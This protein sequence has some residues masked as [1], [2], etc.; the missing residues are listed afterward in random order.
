MIG[1]Q[2][3]SDRCAIRRTQTFH[4]EDQAGGQDEEQDQRRLMKHGIH[5]CMD[6]DA[7]NA[8]GQPGDDAPL[9][10]L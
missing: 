2:H 3:D 1:E 10:R 4:D 7:Q 8:A 6:K 9:P 5:G